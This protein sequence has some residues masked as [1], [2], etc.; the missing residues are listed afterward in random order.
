[1]KNQTQ[2]TTIEDTAAINE[3]KNEAHFSAQSL[4][5]ELAPL[6]KSYFVGEPNFDGNSIDIT[7]L[8]GQK[9]K[10]YAEEV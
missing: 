8:N 5:E 6:I 4:L 3:A 10:I 7:F 1:M 2:I 9:F